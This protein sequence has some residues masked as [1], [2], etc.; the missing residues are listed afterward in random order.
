M[1][2]KVKENEEK[3]KLKVVEKRM[4]KGQ[5]GRLG[6]PPSV[7]HL[8]EVDVLQHRSG[9]SNPNPCLRRLHRLHG[10]G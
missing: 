8:S 1:I 5:E 6:D 10:R 7:V 2:L 3:A 4:R 9:I